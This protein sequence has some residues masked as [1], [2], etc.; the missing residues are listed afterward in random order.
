MANTIDRPWVD[1]SIAG[2]ADRI[3]GEYCELPGLSLTEPQ[4]QRL[5]G[6]DGPVCQCA[7]DLLVRSRLLRRTPSGRYIAG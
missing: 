2:A 7:L 5:F 3:F 6:F 4:M 1:A